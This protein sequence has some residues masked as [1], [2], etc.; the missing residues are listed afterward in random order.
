LQDTKK[1]KKQLIDELQNLHRRLAELE[2]LKMEHQRT[3]QALLKSEEKYRLLV[4]NANDAIFIAQD[5][6]LKFCNQK[7]EEMTGY[8]RQDLSQIPFIHFIHPEDR[9]MVLERHKKRLDGEHPPSKYS[10]RIITKSDVQLWVQLNSVRIDWEG[11]PATLNFLRDINEERRLE[12]QLRYSQKMEAIGTL[13]GGIAHDFNNLLMAIQGYISLMLL[14]TEAAHPHHEYLRNIEKQIKGAAGLTSQLLG[15]AR[16]GKYFAQAFNLNVV[17][18]ETI[19]TLARV[20][21]EITIHTELSEN[22]LTVLADKG[23]IEQVLLNLFANAA[24]AMPGGGEIVF[25]TARV[26]HNDIQ[27][28]AYKPQPGDYVKLTVVDTGVGIDKPTQERIFE[29]FFTSKALGRG[30]GLGLASVYGIIKGHGGYI[31][32]ESSEG[33]GTTFTIYLPAKD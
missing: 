2:A 21:K 33:R 30:T 24:D 15:F 4:E 32:V 19:D 22:P 10:F 23:Q 16:K 31:D 9:E 12:A 6:V 5:D 14:D 17:V 3:A 27:G 13:A 29:P 25:K 7:T 1:T 20:R 11:R 18:K 28:R 26:T 8:K